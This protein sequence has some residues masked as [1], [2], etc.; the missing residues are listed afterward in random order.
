[1]A[2]VAGKQRSDE[3]RRPRPIGRRLARRAKPGSQAGE[4]ERADCAETP[5]TYCD[6]RL[7]TLGETQPTMLR[8]SPAPIAFLG[9][10]GSS[11]RAE[12]APWSSTVINGGRGPCA[13]RANRRERRR[14]HALGAAFSSTHPR[15]SRRATPVLSRPRASSRHWSKAS[16]GGATSTGTRPHLPASE[17]APR[18]PSR[19]AKRDRAIHR[20]WPRRQDR[21]AR[22]TAAPAGSCLQSPSC[23]GSTTQ[24]IRTISPL[25]RRWSRPATSRRTDSRRA[26]D[27]VGGWAR[28]VALSL[29]G[30][31]SPGGR[32]PAGAHPAGRRNSGRAH[33]RVL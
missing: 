2:P 19:P 23:S 7:T 3:V 12:E 13:P 8:G 16:G 27:R 32:I 25:W 6:R 17:S 10:G 18:A 20:E 31:N 14:A 15:A 33:H 24:P 28:D 11:Q 29:W 1:M 21:R 5:R 22:R 26:R 30:P 4:V 9:P